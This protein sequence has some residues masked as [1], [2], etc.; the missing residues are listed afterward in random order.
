MSAI[1]DKSCANKHEERARKSLAKMGLQQVPDVT[2]VTVKIQNQI[3][4]FSQPDVVTI[5][6]SDLYIV[7][8]EPKADDLM[9]RLQQQ[10]APNLG[11][12]KMPSME[13]FQQ[14]AEEADEIED[15]DDDVSEEGL[16]PE[17]IQQVIDQTDASRAKAVRALKKTGTVV[18]A[19][20]ALQ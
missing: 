6:G 3:F 20:L 8:G 18:D 13:Q 5:P 12:M 19:I 10:G 14:Q 17:E 15:G 7:F 9:R 16:D 1:F 2:R 11:D 4:A